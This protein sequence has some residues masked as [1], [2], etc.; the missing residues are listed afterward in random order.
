M[1]GPL[2]DFAA[3][4][5]QL[6]HA[7]DG[8]VAVAVEYLMLAAVAAGDSSEYEIT[9]QIFAVATAV[10]QLFE[11]VEAERGLFYEHEDQ[12]RRDVP[13]ELEAARTVTRQAADRYLSALSSGMFAP[14]GLGVRYTSNVRPSLRRAAELANIVL[15]KKAR[16]VAGVPT[17]RDYC[18]DLERAEDR[19]VNLFEKLLAVLAADFYFACKVGKFLVSD[20]VHEIISL[21]HRFGMVLKAERT[22]FEEEGLE[23]GLLAL[24]GKR[25]AL[26]EKFKTAL[27]NYADGIG[28]AAA[29]QA[30][31]E[32]P[33]PSLS[34]GSR[35]ALLL[36]GTI[37]LSAVC[38]ET[39]AEADETLGEFRSNL[40]EWE[41]VMGSGGKS[42]SDSFVELTS[43]LRS[44]GAETEKRA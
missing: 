29:R 24:R 36:L 34:N 38:G 12:N 1:I 30:A 42:M 32:S 10:V 6:Q 7:L 31:K 3:K 15:N 8:L 18:R 40:A 39:D 2:D 17:T 14:G 33:A 11:A 5:R 41:R 28:P 43:T 13:P 19:A 21:Y 9:P 20:E 26:Q 16:Q 25:T 44:R 23:A 4:S 22:R 37:V 27:S 35:H